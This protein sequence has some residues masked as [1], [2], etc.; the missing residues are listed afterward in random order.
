MC[1]EVGEKN[2]FEVFNKEVKVPE[3]V[4]QKLSLIRWVWH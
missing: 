3:K 2:D 4:D 1:L